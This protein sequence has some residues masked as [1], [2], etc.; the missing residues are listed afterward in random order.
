MI[1]TVLV[2]L[3]ALFHCVILAMEM[4]LWETRPVRP[5]FGISPDFAASTRLTAP[6]RGLCNGFLAAG[7]LLALWRSLPGPR[8]ELVRFILACVIVRGLQGAATASRRILHVQAVPAL[9]ALVAV[10][11]ARWPAGFRWR[12][13][14]RDSE[15]EQSMAG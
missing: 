7:L 4:F 12:P 8:A 3:V 2:A 13:S 14:Q 1:A 9:R 11:T 5:L 6:S 10:L 15:A